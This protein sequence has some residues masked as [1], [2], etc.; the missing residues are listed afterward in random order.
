MCGEFDTK[1]KILYGRMVLEV[2]NVLEL[3]LGFV[4]TFNVVFAHNMC[5]L[6]LNPMFK[7]LQCIM[8]YVGWDRVAT[9]V[10]E[11]D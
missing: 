6:Q 3:F 11:Y 7:R 1:L 2:I 4:M 10:K 5:A 9:I 8:E